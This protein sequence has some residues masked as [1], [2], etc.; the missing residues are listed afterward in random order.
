MAT[1][2]E[3]PGKSNV[4]QEA[5]QQ[6]G[7]D[8][9]HAWQESSQEKAFEKEPQ[10]KGHMRSLEAEHFSKA[11]RQFEHSVDRTL[12]KALDSFE[13]KL[14]AIMESQ[15]GKFQSQLCAMCDNLSS[16]RNQD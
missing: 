3:R 12:Q 8:T 16:N 13:Q 10:D 4:A 6:S 15:M 9:V 1:S 7:A 14:A 2:A 5:S 11:L